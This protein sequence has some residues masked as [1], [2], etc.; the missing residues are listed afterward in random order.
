VEPGCSTSGPNSNFS[1]GNNC[2]VTV[3]KSKET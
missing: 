2:K 3:T 1:H